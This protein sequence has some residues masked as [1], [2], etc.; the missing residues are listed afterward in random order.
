M[1]Y[2]P[3]YKNGPYLHLNHTNDRNGQSYYYDLIDNTSRG[4][5][6]HTYNDIPYTLPDIKNAVAGL[7]KYSVP[8][9]LP[10]VP[11]VKKGF[12]TNLRNMISRN[13]P[14]VQPAQSAQPARPLHSALNTDL[15]ITI[16]DGFAELK[17]SP[18]RFDP[19]P[20]NLIVVIKKWLNDIPTKY[21]VTNETLTI[22]LLQITSLIQHYETL[23]NDDIPGRYDLSQAIP[24]LTTGSTQRPL[25]DYFRRGG[26]PKRRQKTRKSRR[27]RKQSVKRR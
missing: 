2:E 20:S 17:E 23:K 4:P 27:K 21:T 11:P 26:R 19:L 22:L 16:L 12:F 14:N 7:I 13:T 6:N 1:A 10:P 18:N 5:F 25:Y 8:E 15:Y 24:Q 3:V 9:A